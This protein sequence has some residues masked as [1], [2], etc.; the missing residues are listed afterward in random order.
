[1]R[2]WPFLAVWSVA[3]FACGGAP[4][5]KS[6]DAVPLSSSGA[7][8]DPCVHYGGPP[9]TKPDV[10]APPLPRDLPLGTV[11]RT[12]TVDTG[13][14]VHVHIART[15]RESMG[16]LMIR[17]QHVL[18]PGPLVNVPEREVPERLVTE[19]LRPPA[20]AA[21]LAWYTADQA[22]RT[23]AARGAWASEQLQ[24]CGPPAIAYTCLQKT[25]DDADAK[26]SV[27]FAASTEA[28]R[29]LVEVLE[30]RDTADRSAAEELVLA[31]ALRRG[32]PQD[33]APD[34]QEEAR[35]LSHL[36]AA[37]SLAA[38]TEL[39]WH[40]QYAIASLYARAQSPDALAAYE[41]LSILP[42]PPAC[43]IEAI[44]RH[45]ELLAQTEKGLR[46]YTAAAKE[47]AEFQG[48]QARKWQLTTQCGL[49]PTA[50]ALERDAEALTAASQCSSLSNAT[51]DDELAPQIATLLER[52]GKDVSLLAILFPRPLLGKIA[53]RL[54]EAA[55]QRLAR[56]S[57]MHAFQ[58][59]IELSPDAH[60]QIAARK[61]LERLAAV[62]QN[63]SPNDR[64]AELLAR[65]KDELPLSPG[66]KIHV[67]VSDAH[68]K[69]LRLAP[70]RPKL[71]ACITRYGALYAEDLAG[72]A[73]DL[74]FE[75]VR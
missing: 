34:P 5:M 37:V 38:N 13:Q 17:S 22:V 16:Q 28:R 39:R 10:A 64:A 9:V 70:E 72:T 32:W 71:R 4:S 35:V 56:G 41:R 48:P 43:H 33:D 40:A 15:A 60:I 63:Q 55:S 24:I 19:G 59:A 23:Q 49:V 7:R 74:T 73:L 36:G 42:A 45:A 14:V 11:R 26:R 29:K 53:F 6:I 3:A 65:C 1:M 69:V 67:L 27:S 61:E 25:L 12:P 8:I 62:T 21:F 20:R 46:L 2:R 44:F 54:G 50:V 58:K 30:G 57:A 75:M 51:F 18:P 68:V 66:T 31:A 52:S 47:A